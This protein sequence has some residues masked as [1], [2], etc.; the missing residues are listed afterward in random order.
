MTCSCGETSP[1]IVARRLTFDG[2]GIAVLHDGAITGRFGTALEGVPVTRPR[3]R[4]AT[5]LARRTGALFAG[6]VEIH[7]YSDLGVLYQAC[8][9]AA[10]RDGLPGSV[11]TR[12]YQLQNPTIAPVWTVTET[13]RD[14]N[15][16]ERVWRLPRLRWP[17]IVVFDHV[18]HGARGR[19]EVTTLVPGTDTCATTGVSFR[20]LAEL[21]TYL[22]SS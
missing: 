1:H 18:N 11:R 20:T 10:A 19:Y 12:F 21:S 3:T 9:W 16:T 14:G 17:G 4:K 13:D 2:I 22:L 7:N 15:P 6:E 5:E 8:R